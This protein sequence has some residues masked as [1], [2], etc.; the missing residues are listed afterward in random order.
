[1]VACW[2]DD[3]CLCR[4][5]LKEQTVKVFS[6]R[7]NKATDGTAVTYM[8]SHDGT[9]RTCCSGRAGRHRICMSTK[10]CCNYCESCVGRY[11]GSGG[12]VPWRVP[13]HSGLMGVEMMLAHQVG[14]CW[15]E[16]MTGREDKKG[17]DRCGEISICASQ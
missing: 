14:H 3:G 17:V 1:M 9:G 16:S 11:C 2:D 15:V 13:C 10:E 5:E 6:G 8:Y 7:D 4:W 12:R